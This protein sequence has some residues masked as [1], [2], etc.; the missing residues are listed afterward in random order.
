[1]YL[2]G[3]A[4][5]TCPVSH[6]T[7]SGAVFT[8]CKEQFRQ[9]YE[10]AFDGRAITCK[11]S[12]VAVENGVADLELKDGSAP[13]PNGA[14]AT[15]GFNGDEDHGDSDDDEVVEGDGQTQP[16]GTDGAAKKKKKRKP[17]KKKKAGAGASGGGA[18][19]QSAP[20][21]IPVA[22]LFPNNAYPVGE[23]VEYKNDNAYRTT[24][25]EKRHLDRI[26]QDFLT[27]YRQA[28]EV[29]RQVRK[30]AKSVIRPGM[31]LTEIAETIEDGTR[32][33]T[34]HMGLEEGDNILGGVAFPTG[35]SLNHCA[36]HYTPNAGNKTVLK[37]E[38][39]MKVDFGV[40]V[41]GRIVDSAFT[42]AFEPQYDNLL[43]AVKDATNTGIR[44]AGIDARMGEIGEAIQEAMESYEVEINGT[45]F[46]VKAIRNL[47]GHTISQWSIHGGS[48]GKSVPIVK[49]V[50]N[51]KM[52]EGETY[53]IETFG[54][55][56]K[57]VVRD[58]METS[59]Y[60]KVSDAPK[61]ALRVAS[62]KTLLR[63]IDKN[64]GTLPFCRRYLDRLGHDKY[65]LG[66]NNLV[67]SGIVQDYPPLVDVKGS[68]T[69]QYE[70]TILLRPNVKE[71]ISRGDDY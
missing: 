6:F 16:D 24:S 3:A 21:R 27:E 17:R 71:V 14:T 55:T 60:A 28:A 4:R 42:V 57:G 40:H 11:M 50:N 56:G 32:H 46:P 67:Q 68:Y 8:C 15:N 61:V 26:N 33:L 63:S 23:E 51:E 44:E 5:S 58:D 43:A 45:T 36:A 30:Y 31:S 19:E 1:V 69:A 41:N 7:N 59:H 2:Y 34:G 35:L 18:K 10:A 54:S 47:N 39:V 20:P 13:S 48:H 52:E 38:D 37:Q 62:A 12:T 49:G 64:F 65:L 66:L 53:A 25:E 22:Q 9:F 70:H 29:H